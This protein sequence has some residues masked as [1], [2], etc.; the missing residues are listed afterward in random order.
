MSNDEIVHR[1]KRSWWD[2]SGKT[3]C[4]LRIENADRVVLP[5]VFGR[6]LCPA[7]E[8]ANKPR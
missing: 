3:L 1:G 5:R 4:G 2:G 7:C 6:T 8:A